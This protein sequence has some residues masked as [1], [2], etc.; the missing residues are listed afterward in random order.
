MADFIR[1]LKSYKQ[2]WFHRS[3]TRFGSRPGKQPGRDP[4]ALRFDWIW[5]AIASFEIKKMMKSP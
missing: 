3:K 2:I 1:K 4:Q 5:L